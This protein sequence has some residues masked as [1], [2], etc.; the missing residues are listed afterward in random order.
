MADQEKLDVEQVLAV[1]RTPWEPVFGKQTGVCNLLSTSGEMESKQQK[2]MMENKGSHWKM[3]RKC[4]CNS[5]VDQIDSAC[6]RKQLKSMGLLKDAQRAAV[7]RRE[8]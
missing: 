6:P 1:R 2:R 4:R 7:H 5:E 8:D 3:K